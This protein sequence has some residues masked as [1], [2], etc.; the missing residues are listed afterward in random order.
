MLAC[1]D[2]ITPSARW[3]RHWMGRRS[4][5]GGSRG[6]AVAWTGGSSRGLRSGQLASVCSESSPT[7]VLTRCVHK[8]TLLVPRVRREGWYTWQRPPARGP[9]LL[10]C[11]TPPSWTL[12]FR[13]LLIISLGETLPCLNLP[14]SRKPPTPTAWLPCS[15]QGG[16]LMGTRLRPLVHWVRAQDSAQ[17]GQCRVNIC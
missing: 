16:D 8:N 9:P 4:R 2:E 14:S 6:V 13:P 12:F 3:R 10:P 7:W 11:H 5:L 1:L 17:H 15:A